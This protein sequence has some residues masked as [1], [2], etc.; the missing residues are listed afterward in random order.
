[1]SQ[2]SERGS[3]CGE[4]KSDPTMIKQLNRSAELPFI[5]DYELVKNLIMP[6]TAHPINLEQANRNS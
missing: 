4:G 3:H 5:D 1:M 6:L 2:H